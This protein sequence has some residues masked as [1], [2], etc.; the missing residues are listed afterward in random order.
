[1]KIHQM[2]HAF[3]KVLFEIIGDGAKPRLTNHR[4]LS[5]GR[6]RLLTCRTCTIFAVNSALLLYTLLLLLPPP[7][8]LL[9]A[10]HGLVALLSSEPLRL[11]L[12]T[13]GL[14]DERF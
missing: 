11:R 13:G 10:R 3:V 2:S 8:L 9:S 1:M 12:Q 5:R 7:P 4:R 14:A 6:R